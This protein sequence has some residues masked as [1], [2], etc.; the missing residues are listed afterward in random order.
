VAHV[1]RVGHSREVE[2]PSAPLGRRVAWNTGVQMGARI[3]TLAISF[4]SIVLLTRYLGVEGYGDFTAALVYVG[5]YFVF[6]DLGT[7]PLLVRQLSQGI[8]P[9]RELIGKALMLRF[10][11]S[12]LVTV[13]AA[14]LPFLLYPGEDRE[15]LRVGIMIAL[16]TIAIHAVANT[17]AAIF[18]AE[19]KLDRLALAEIVSQ[20]TLVL[21]IVALVAT[22]QSFYAIMAATVVSAAVNAAVIFALGRRLVPISPSVDVPYWKRL[23]LDSLPLGLALVISTIYFRVDALLL[24]VLKDSDDVGIY[25]V[26]YRFFETATPFAYFLVASL[27]PLLS[28]AAATGDRDSVLNLSQR[29]F[30]ALS[31]GAILVVA[32]IVATAP[33]VVE[34]VAGSDFERAATPLRIVIV[35]A[36]LTFLSTYLAYLL[37]SVDRQRSVLWLSSATLLFNVVLNLAL[38]P[39]YGYNAAACVATG[40]QAV[41]LAGSLW[42]AHRHTGFLPE[43]GVAARGLVAGAAMFLAA[44]LLRGNVVLALAVGTLVYLG[45]LYLLRVHESIQL[46]TILFGSRR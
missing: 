39:E 15:Q 41:L 16:P 38:I 23:F 44:Y 2:L 4:V 1:S 29:A 18:Q 20:L 21:L 40:S 42:L 9:A 22:D 24:S 33:G 25:G 26:A 3:V 11:L 13:A 37:I 32:G 12:L 46:R 35:G 31:L 34:L 27:F 10:G 14:P 8:A 43:V 6:F 5:L 7:Y 17:I 28:A 30:D 36:G 45:G 19:L